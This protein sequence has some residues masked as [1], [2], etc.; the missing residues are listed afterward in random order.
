MTPCSIALYVA[1]SVCLMETVFWILLFS[2]Y[3]PKLLDF[4]LLKSAWA[5]VCKRSRSPGIDFKELIPPAWESI[6]RLIKRFTNSCSADLFC[7]YHA[8]CPPP[9]ELKIK[10]LAV[11]QLVP[12]RHERKAEEV[13]CC[14]PVPPGEG[15][16]GGGGGRGDMFLHPCPL[17]DLFPLP[18]ERA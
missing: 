12:G 5:R 13:D 14:T 7:W 4:S 18:K 3:V 17:M 10:S 15:E 1:A 8:E 16:G 9:Q 2:S 11:Y 6:P